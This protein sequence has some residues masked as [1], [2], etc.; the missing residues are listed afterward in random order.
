VNFLIDECL[1]TS[2]VEVAVERGHE[3]T[4]VNYRGLSG[5]QDWSLMAP[6]REGEFTFVTNNAKDFRRLYAREEI[7]AGLVILIPNVT[8]EV[9]R[10]LFAAALDDLGEAVGLINEALEVGVV[11]GE[12]Q[13]TRHELPRDDAAVDAEP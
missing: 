13:I 8:P 11:D 12:I 10:V 5:V 9:Q 6:I 1:H 3:A 4:H 7:H 2:L